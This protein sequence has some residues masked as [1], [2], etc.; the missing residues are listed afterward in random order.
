MPVEL[1]ATASGEPVKPIA[2]SRKK[3]MITIPIRTIL[4]IS[5]TLGPAR[6]AARMIARRQNENNRLGNQTAK[7]SLKSCILPM[8]GSTF[9]RQWPSERYAPVSR[10]N[11]A[12]LPGE[13]V[14][15]R[16]HFRNTRG[17][18]RPT[19]LGQRQPCISTG[20]P[21]CLAAEKTPATTSSRCQTPLEQH[22]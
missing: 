6:L 2:N 5:E 16:T 18:P 15:R 17:A 10:I 9:R 13:T 4:K 11:S 7:I 12:V 20:P 22:G 14:A 1:F 19:G 8:R 3:L 21:R